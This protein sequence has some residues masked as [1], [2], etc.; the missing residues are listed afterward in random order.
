[1][2]FGEKIKRLRRSKGL[3]QDQLAQR[4]SVSRQAVSKWEMDLSYPDAENIILLSDLFEV[5]TDTL[6]KEAVDLP[7]PSGDP[8]TDPRPADPPPTDPGQS[9]PA[10]PSRPRYLAGKA[11]AVVFLAAG[12]SGALALG[13]LSSVFPA[14]LTQPTPVGQS[15]PA[16]TETGLS[17]FLQMHGLGW[18][19]TLCLG[20][21]VCGAFL[22]ALLFLFPRLRRKK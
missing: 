19:F 18:L 9:A 7:G 20:S 1:M 14:F 12:L 16:Q 10:G 4:L 11:A 13:I 6:L 21:A 22:L 5:T 15:G 2:T 3:S 17:A 8:R